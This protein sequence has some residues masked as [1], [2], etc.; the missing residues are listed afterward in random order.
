MGA[1]P[2]QNYT[3]ASIY[4]S[5]NTSELASRNVPA[6]DRI[7]FWD[8]SAQQWTFLTVGTNLAISGTTLNATG[9]APVGAEYLVKVADATLTA[10]RV[11]T[12]TSTVTWD[13]TDA[14]KAKANVVASTTKVYRA[15]ISQVGAFVD[16]TVV[17]LENT[18]GGTPVFVR[19]GAG[20]FTCTLATAFTATKTFVLIGTSSHAGGSGT[21]FTIY[22]CEFT[23]T[24]V[25]SFYSVKFAAGASSLV[26]DEL[27]DTA[28]EILIYP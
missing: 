16:P 23:S 20:A 27:R 28:F 8:T 12:D 24:S 21:S 10:E 17:V 1:G 25:I 18:L 15:T 2:R 3:S 22:P 6:A 9:V 19:T 5:P 26:D 7:W 14:T 11:V 13:W 4:L